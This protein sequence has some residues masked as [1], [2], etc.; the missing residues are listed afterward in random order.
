MDSDLDFGSIP[1]RDRGDTPHSSYRGSPVPLLLDGNTLGTDTDNRSLGLPL[2][3]SNS[4][5]DTY[6][7]ADSF[8]EAHPLSLS[9]FED[10]FPETGYK[11]RLNILRID[12]S[13]LE[14]RYLKAC[15]QKIQVDEEKSL[16]ERENSKL[17]FENEFLKDD[18]I[19]LAAEN[20][21]LV[22]EN[23]RLLAENARLQ[24]KIDF[25]KDIAQS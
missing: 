21:R 19:R 12:Y 4:G 14:G 3:L 15:E 25:I 7:P 2:S 23:A 16:L 11:H 20:S 5:D 6:E 17:E 9:N 8:E 22:A 24:T 10:M 18:K 1:E 13:K